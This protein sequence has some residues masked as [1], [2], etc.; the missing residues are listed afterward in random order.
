MSKQF[1]FLIVFCLCLIPVSVPSQVLAGELE[2]IQSFSSRIEINPDASV[3]VQEKIVY[4][5]GE[6]QRHGIFR[7]I[8]VDY[9][10]STGNYSLRITVESVTD[11]L[12]RSY[13]FTTSKNGGNL[14]IRIGDPDVLVSGEHT[15]V[16]NYAVDRA[17]NFF[18]E[19]DELYWNVTG[20]QWSVPINQA[21]AAVI[22]PGEFS[23]K[24]LETA[25]FAGS[26]GS[27]NV[28]SSHMLVGSDNGTT[29]VRFEQGP[30]NSGN[31]LT[32][33]VN[34]PKGLVAE[35][36]LGQKF[37][38]TLKDNFILLLPI[39]VFVFLFF[40]WRSHGRDPQ[41]SGTI[42]AQYDPP[43]GLSPAEVGTVVD[44]RVDRKDISAELIHLAVLGYLK[45]KQVEKKT[46]MFKETDYELHKLRSEDDL[47][48][49]FQKTLLQKLF[50][51]GDDKVTL[52][53]LKKKFA[54]SYKEIVKEVYQSTVE[55]GYF[56]KSPQKVRNIYWL[57]GSAMF[58]IS[59]W[60]INV[61]GS[62]GALSLAVSGVLFIIFS[63]FMP[64]RT[65]AGVR[66]R[67]HILGLKEYLSVAEAERLKF[68][69]APA[70]QPERFEALLPYAMA[71]GVEK[72]WAKQ[73]ADIYQGQPSWYEGSQ[74]STFNAIVLSNSLSS[75]A[76]ASDQTLAVSASRGGS[77]VGGGGFSGG[78]FGGG[79]GGSW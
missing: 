22:L 54:K 8:P 72:Q 51:S 12:G 69:N 24:E 49:D 64:A 75:F 3:Q 20:N 43:E 38:A 39:A 27:A 28:C 15:Y 25:C 66:V 63:F 19:G 11:G 59:F 74:L 44:E 48:K 50:S 14:R 36:S 5:F 56:A 33:A 4:D 61:F 47:S 41:S 70:R 26:F 21:Q 46:W 57:F 31:G 53:G 2:Q 18:D 65:Q 7:D 73:F 13:Q 30:L 62:F 29:E 76:K 60:L 6:N 71:L 78:G 55:Q 32:I 79:G 35:P 37:F 23:E 58:F 52:S 77:G 45:I 1:L 67:E 34:F 17:I 42:V 68:H 16:I 10:T 9:E 40:R